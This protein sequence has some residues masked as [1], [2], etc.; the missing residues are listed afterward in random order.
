MQSFTYRKTL[1]CSDRAQGQ[2]KYC[3]ITHRYL[4]YVVRGSDNGILCLGLLGFLIVSIISLKQEHY[5]S[6]M[7]CVSF[8]RWVGQEAPTQ[9]S[10]RQNCCQSL[11]GWYRLTTY[12]YVLGSSF[13]S[14]V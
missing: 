12:T 3:F 10:D 11:D 6:E 14:G 13:V 9:V 5:I 7:G 2:L 8:L 1:W 4:F